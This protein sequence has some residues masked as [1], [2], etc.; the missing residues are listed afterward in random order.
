MSVEITPALRQA[1]HL[2]ALA[3]HL[4]R[5][6][7]LTPVNVHTRAGDEAQ[8]LQARSGSTA[9]GLVE[10]ADSLTE[11]HVS[12]QRIGTEAFVFV[13]GATPTTKVVVWTTVPGLLEHLG[14]KSDEEARPVAVE[15]LR[16]FAAVEGVA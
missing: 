12:I 8:Q 1:A 13:S 10:W 2:M 14:W 11:P 4:T 9:R 15:E 7:D 5:H 6:P 16:T 3:Q